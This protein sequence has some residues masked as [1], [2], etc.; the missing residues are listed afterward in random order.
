MPGVS[1]EIQFKAE[2]PDAPQDE[3][4]PSQS[5]PRR[6]NRRRKASILEEEA[7][8]QRETSNGKSQASTATSGRKRKS[9]F[10]LI[11]FYL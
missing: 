7:E 10:G 9:N 4:Q 5:K 1:E 2:F 3:C 8:T 11:P 6:S